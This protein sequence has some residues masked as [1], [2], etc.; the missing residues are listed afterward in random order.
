[1]SGPQ[2]HERL[3]RSV[4]PEFSSDSSCS[5][6]WDP[7]FSP[8]PPPALSNDKP[9]VEDSPAWASDACFVVDEPDFFPA[10]AVPKG[11]SS[12]G[13]ISMRK[14]NWSDLLSALAMSER[15]SVRR[16]LASATM[17]ALAVISEIKTGH[18]LVRRNWI[19][20][21]ISAIQTRENDVCGM[22]IPSAAIILRDVD[23]KLAKKA[24]QQHSP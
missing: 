14:S 15:D 21:V 6:T 7:P 24:C 20:A 11:I 13:T 2:G 18:Q 19:G 12:L 1:M 9:L 4:G 8:E 17:K 16:L 23:K 5:S 3:P 22:C 10:V